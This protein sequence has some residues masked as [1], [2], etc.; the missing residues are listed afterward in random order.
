MNKEIVLTSCPVAGMVHCLGTEE[1][2]PDDIDGEYLDLYRD[3][4]NGHDRWAIKVVLDDR[5]IGW[6]PSNSNRVF[7]AMMDGNL[8][9]TARVSVV[10]HK[11]IRKAGEPFMWI[12]IIWV[13]NATEKELAAEVV[14]HARRKKVRRA[15]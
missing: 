14:K 9:L 1:E 4:L 13:R 3:P 7:A 11:K 10:K 8:Q 5:H 15:M 2:Y 6:V 12:D